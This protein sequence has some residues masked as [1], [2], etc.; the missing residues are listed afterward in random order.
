APMPNQNKPS[1]PLHL[2]EPHIRWLWKARLTD[3][4][5]VAEL[6]KQ[7][8]TDMYGIGLTKFVE[9]CNSLGL[10]CT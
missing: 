4:D 2:I 10:Q 7:I 5:I 9:I 8:D 6:H 3:K 1:P